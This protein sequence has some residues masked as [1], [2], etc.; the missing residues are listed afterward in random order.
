MRVV[1]T[2][3]SSVLKRISLQNMSSVAGKSVR[4]LEIPADFIKD[5][6]DRI[7]Q[8]LNAGVEVSY[9]EV[10]RVL[11]INFPIPVDVTNHIPVKRKGA[12]IELVDRRILPFNLSETAEGW[13]RRLQNYRGQQCYENLGDVIRERCGLEMA[14][15]TTDTTATFYVQQVLRRHVEEH[16]AVIV[17]NAYFETFT[18]HEKR[19]CGVHFLLKGYVL[20]RP[21]ECIDPNGSD[22]TQLLTCYNITPHF[23]DPKMQNDAETNVIKFVA[24]VTSANISTTNEALENLLVDE[25]LR[26]A[27]MNV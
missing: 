13:W 14:D 21:M 26:K 5:V 2:S 12:S 16:R 9:Q 7:F 20:M 3:A 17:W 27:Q 22:A 4:R 25:A 1:L 10:E 6:A 11:E 18:F 8:Q 19:V 23:S 15:V 24:S